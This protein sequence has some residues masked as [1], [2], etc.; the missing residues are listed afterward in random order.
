MSFCRVFPRLFAVCFVLSLF[1]L[2]TLAQQVPTR[3]RRAGQDRQPTTPNR[4]DGRA[5]LETDLAAD[6]PAQGEEDY[7]PGDSVE[8]FVI[9][10]DLGH[11]EREML[12]AIDER[13]GTPYRMGATGPN[14]YDCSGFVW[15]VFQQAGV[16]FERSSARS[17]WREV[18]PPPQGGQFKFGPLGFFHNLHHIGILADAHRLL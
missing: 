4:D 15:R 13:L 8:G 14:R 16:S 17:L 1:S 7:E 9:P 18:A 12:V 2:T 6:A 3:P 5:R 11:V 10:R